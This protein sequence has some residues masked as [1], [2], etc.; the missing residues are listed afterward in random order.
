MVFL[1]GVFC[2]FT[3]GSIH[4]HHFKS[5]SL[6]HLTTECKR[7]DSSLNF[8]DNFHLPLWQL[9]TFC[10]N[11]PSNSKLDRVI[12]FSNNKTSHQPTQMVCKFLSFSFA[13]IV[14]NYV[15]GNNYRNTP[16]SAATAA[17]SSVCSPSA[18]F[19]ASASSGLAASSSVLFS[20]SLSSENWEASN[21]SSCLVRIFPSANLKQYQ[22]FSEIDLMSQ[23]KK[24]RE[25]FHSFF[26]RE[27]EF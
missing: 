26:F 14:N 2:D 24:E 15:I 19:A 8:Q 1:A 16:D 13:L 9:T 6:I 25:A 17:A 27:G 11:V 10:K 5:H 7:D 20:V 22:M 18:G 3:P 12:T 21:C 4:Y 23:T